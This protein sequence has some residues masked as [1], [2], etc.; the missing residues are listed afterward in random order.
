MDWRDPTQ[1]YCAFQP[2]Y[3]RYVLPVQP[4]PIIVDHTP[5]LQHEKSAK[6]RAAPVMDATLIVC[7]KSQ[8]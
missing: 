3:H 7:R 6:K 2:E 1:V 4:L 8:T 5:R